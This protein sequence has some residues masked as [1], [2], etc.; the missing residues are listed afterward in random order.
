MNLRL[1]RLDRFGDGLP[2][3]L[4]VDGQH[5]VVTL[6]NADLAIAAGRYQIVM[7]ESGRA[8]AGGLWSPRDDFK[9]PLLCDVAGHE[10]IR[11]HAANVASELAGCIAPGM[12][13]DGDAI[14]QSRPALINVM[15]KID[16]AIALGEEV[17]IDVVDSA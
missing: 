7:T 14:Q 16:A 1:Q 5:C 15:A 6:E 13:R 11:L 2:G 4:Y 10:G 17:W 9:L 8:R 12:A 3:D